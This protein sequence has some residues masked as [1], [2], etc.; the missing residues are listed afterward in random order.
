MEECLPRVVSLVSVLSS[1]PHCLAQ[2][3]IS[4]QLD[5]FRASQGR[6][7]PSVSALLFLSMQPPQMAS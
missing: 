6:S 4:S 5:P 7:V 3:H 2:G 1:R